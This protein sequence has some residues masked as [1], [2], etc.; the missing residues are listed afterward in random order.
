MPQ[1]LCGSDNLQ[2]VGIATTVGNGRQRAALARQWLRALA[3]PDHSVPVLP[4]CDANTAGCQRPPGFAACDDLE[5]AAVGEENDTARAVLQLMCRCCTP[6]PSPAYPPVT[7]SMKHRY[8]TR[9]VVIAIAPLTPLAAALQLDEKDGSLGLLRLVNRV[10]V[11]GQAEVSESPPFLVS[12]GDSAYNFRIDMAAASEVLQQLHAA[13]RR[14][15]FLGK[16]AAYQIS[17]TKQDLESLDDPLIPSLTLVARDQMQEFKRQN[18]SQ[19][20]HLFPVPERFR[21]G[22]NDADFAWFQHLPGG[23]VSHPY[24]ALLVL[25]AEEDAASS[26]PLFARQRLSDHFEAVGNSPPPAAHGVVD[27]HAVKSAMLL[28]IRQAIDRSRVRSSA[29]ARSTL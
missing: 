1:A 11:Q 19:F 14:V 26:L 9:L 13:Q 29:A 28:L 10:Y 21:S 25:M 16:H 15:S 27:A 2:L 4:L 5:A 18:P 20:Y 3:V 22:S 8:S 24:D 23:V 12:P 6:T 7:R 17:L